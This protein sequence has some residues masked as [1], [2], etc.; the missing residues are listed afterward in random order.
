M[1]LWRN[2]EGKSD[3]NWMHCERHLSLC[4]ALVPRSWVATAV[5]PQAPRVVSG[6]APLLPARWEPSDL[7]QA[8][9]ARQA[10]G[11]PA[12]V[13]EAPTEPRGPAVPSPQ[14]IWW[15]PCLPPHQ[16][17]GLGATQLPPRPARVSVVRAG[18]LL[19]FSFAF[20]LIVLSR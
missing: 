18:V 16:P 1:Q 4:Q 11:Q 14:S 2:L 15:S 8:W 3:T 12:E 13:P 5:E 17:L 6:S 20:L 19:S 9:G 7:R 10:S